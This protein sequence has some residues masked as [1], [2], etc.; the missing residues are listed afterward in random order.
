MKNFKIPLI[1]FAC[2]VS[3]A[4]FATIIS[5]L[6]YQPKVMVK[7]GFQIELSAN[8]TAVKKEVKLVDFATLMK[9]ADLKKGKKT[10]KKCASCHTFNKGGKAKV[11]PNLYKIIGK[12]RAAMSGFSYSKAMKA[13]GGKWN[14]KSIDQFITKPKDFIPGT[15]MGFRGI[16]K[17]QDRA[18]L[19]LFL[20][21]TK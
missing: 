20:E 12:K 14:R 9:N 15:K 7:R 11:G 16:K 4:V 10:A 6:L 19:I 3:I 21:Q 17:P 13:K 5:S 1:S 2:A 18:N 8:G